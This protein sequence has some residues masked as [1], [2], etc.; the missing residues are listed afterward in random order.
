MTDSLPQQIQLPVVWVGVEEE[1]VEMVNQFLGQ[2]VAPDEIVVTVGHFSPP[3]V[4]GSAEQQAEQL[5]NTPFVQVRP[6]SRFGLTP[7]RLRELVTIL[8]TTLAQTD[9]LADL[10]RGK[11]EQ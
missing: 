8:Q 2:V 7:S 3:V 9:R 10:E 4:L 11:R 1:P 6:V 5:R